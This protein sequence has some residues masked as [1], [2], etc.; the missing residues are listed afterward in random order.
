[1]AEDLEKLRRIYNE[2]RHSV[3]DSESWSK[4]AELARSLV[5]GTKDRSGILEQLLKIELN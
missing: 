5:L 1:M 3:S 2:A 4:K